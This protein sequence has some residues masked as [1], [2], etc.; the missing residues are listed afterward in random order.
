MTI[1]E[2]IK[3]HNLRRLPPGVF[4]PPELIQNE[5]LKECAEDEHYGNPPARFVGLCRKNNYFFKYFLASSD[6]LSLFDGEI[7][8]DYG[9]LN[10][11]T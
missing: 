8:K 2:Y 11:S 9:E 5:R 6:R 3:H 4:R 7:G 10:S 1:E